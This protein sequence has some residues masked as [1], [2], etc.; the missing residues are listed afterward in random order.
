LLIKD[1][2]ESVVV[3]RQSLLIWNLVF[4]FSFGTLSKKSGVYQHH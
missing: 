1:I 2:D 4:E 3:F